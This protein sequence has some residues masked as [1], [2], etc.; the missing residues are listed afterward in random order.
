M[1][2]LFFKKMLIDY[3]NEQTALTK[4]LETL[5][6]DL[7]KCESD[8]RDISAWINRIK[9]CISI[10]SLDRGILVELIDS[11]TV[12]ERYKVSGENRQDIT[13]KYKFVGCL[14]EHIMCA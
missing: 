8:M 13:I 7:S 6:K 5:Q 4:T 9:S 14:E 3:E 2:D 12:S 10:D 11:I 1:P